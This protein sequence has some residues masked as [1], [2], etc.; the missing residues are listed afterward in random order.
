MSYANQHVL[1]LGMGRSGA[2]A[3]ELLLR[4][5]ARVSAYDRD[6]AALADLSAPVTRID[7]AELPAFSDYDAVVAS[8]G[9][10]LS[11]APELIPEVDLAAE[12]L[13][14]PIVGVTGTNGKSTVTVMIGEMLRA[15]GF[16]TGVG[17]NLGT[18]L[19]EFVDRPELASTTGRSATTRRCKTSRS[20]NES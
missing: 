14:V 4:K 12:F 19:C 9:F 16:E 3:L 1:V 2:A 6:P 20:P 13:D 7:H 15:S 18:P 10:A 5:G 11:S 17:G 8:P